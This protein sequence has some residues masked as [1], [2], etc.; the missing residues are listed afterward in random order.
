MTTEKTQ[1][2][3]LNLDLTNWERSCLTSAVGAVPTATLNDVEN[4]LEFKK[5]IE[6]P[7]GQ[8]KKIAEKP[9][10]S[11]V[12]SL[13]KE[14]LKYAW[15]KLQTVQGFPVAERTIKLRKKIHS[16]LETN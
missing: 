7:E 1:D 10:E 14:T 13:K 9:D 4:L 8:E 16:K 2:G 3:I 6:I 11:T 5:A 15:N 12:I